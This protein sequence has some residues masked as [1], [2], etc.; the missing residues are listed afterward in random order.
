MPLLALVPF[1][2]LLLAPAEPAPPPDVRRSLQVLQQRV[3]GR[4]NSVAENFSFGDRAA[5]VE[6]LQAA[7]KL[8]D[9]LVKEGAAASPTG[10][11]FVP[12]A[13]AERLVALRADLDAM[14]KDP[15]KAGLTFR[16]PLYMETLDP[17]ERALK[18]PRALNFQGSYTETKVAEEAV[19]GHASAMAPPVR[20]VTADED[21]RGGASLD[22]EMVERPVLPEKSWCG[23]KTKDHIIESGGSGV[24]LFDYDGDG[25]LDVYTVSAYELGPK[26]EKIPHRNALYKNLGGFRFEDVSA[27]AGVGAA[28]W[29]N[30]VCAGDFDDDGRLDLYVTNF[31]PN[32]LYRNNGDGTFTDVAEKAGVAAG[33]WSTGCSFLDADGDGDLDLYVARYMTTTWDEIQKAERTHTWRGGPKVMMGPV[34]LPGAADLFYENKGNGT[35]A[36]ATEAHGLK[37]EAKAYGFAVVPVD[38]DGDGATDLFVAND[39]NPN[40]LYHNDG[41]GRFESL[42]LVAGVAVNGE[43]R[44]QAGMGA[45]AGDYDGDGLPDLVLTTFANDTVSVY[46]NLGRGSFEDASQ[47]CGVAARTYAP[48]EWGTLFFDADRDGDLDLFLAEGHIYPQVDEHPDLQESYRQKN[49][50]LLNEGGRFRDVSE[51]AGSGL[52][53]K[54]SSRGLAVGDLDNDGDLD[55]VI[56]NIDATPTVLEN[57]TAA[58]NHWVS[59][60]LEKAGRNRF[61]FGAQVTLTAGD[62]RQTREVRSGG[63]YLS[64]SDLRPFFGLGAH[65]G[66]VDVEVRLPGQGRWVWKAVPVDRVTTLTLDDT[67][68]K[69]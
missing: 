63:S 43:G 55:L 54:E 49:Q 6:D 53:V 10:G 2:S 23:G 46:R 52:Q 61:A 51:Q 62:K 29:G 42:G 7:V 40:F 17:L 33:S 16:L 57:R 50:L 36:E 30:G 32:F 24:A 20:Q 59:F 8:L 1:V 41:K 9:V 3:V 5:A 67:H 26:K 21:A 56:T 14:A 34:G 25:L 48:M 47:A 12:A 64:Q 58:A 35:F 11:P 31:G 60:R 13:M 27:K 19:G 22:V 44:S 37:D 66:P 45:D 38:Y 28:V 18:P 39:S 15:V 69:D 65:A 4:L 68:R